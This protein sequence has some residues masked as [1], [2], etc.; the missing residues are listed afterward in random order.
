MNASALRRFRWWHEAALLTL[1]VV[2]VAAAGTAMPNFVELRGQ[3]ILSRHL[4]ETAIL[5]LGMT[6]III[7]GGIDLSVGSAMGL[8]AVAF[9]ICYGATDSLAWSCLACVATG[10]FGGALNGLLI[11][12]LEVHPLIITLATYAGFRGIAEGVSQGA[13]YSRFGEG[14]AALA[15]GEWLGV[16]IPAYIFAVLAIAFAVFLARTPT[17]RFLYA[18]GHSERAARFS[19]IPVDRIKFALYTTSGLLA[20]LATLIYVSRFNT[21]KADAGTGLEL[22]VIT[23]VVIGGTSIFGGRGNIGGTLLG[24]LLIHEAQLFVTRYWRIDELRSILVG[25]LL[26]GSIL[27]YRMVMPGDRE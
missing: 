22:D 6:L 4:W 13:S 11:S 12:R 27:V 15:R 7:T 18:I 1:L 23:A 20:G 5:A 17:G 26:I 3:L 14:Y 9:G 10:A 2:L 8:C 21:A 16:P 19:G 24:L 25:A